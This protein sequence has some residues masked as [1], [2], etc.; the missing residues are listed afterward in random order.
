MTEKIWFCKVGGEADF[1]QGGA[2][3][4]MRRAISKAFRDIT[5]RDPEFIFSGWAATLTEGER[6]VV[7]NR[8]PRLCEADRPHQYE[9]K[10]CGIEPP[11]SEKETLPAH[12]REDAPYKQCSVCGRK[13]WEDPEH[14]AI[15]WMPQPSGDKCHGV[16]RLAANR[17][18]S[19]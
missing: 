3:A 17:G 11:C 12:L 2:D 13:S 18:E 16:L 7:E 9:C 14:E 15:C 19:L 10:N 8:A 1:F 4:P 6:A 5:G